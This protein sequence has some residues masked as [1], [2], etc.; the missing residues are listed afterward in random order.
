MTP[1]AATW[2]CR[3]SSVEETGRETVQYEHV[4][5]RAHHDHLVCLHCGKQVEFQYPAIDVLQEEVAREYGFELKRHHLELI[6]VCADC[7]TSH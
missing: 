6:G 2:P 5:G 1:P 7:R 4:W 3:A